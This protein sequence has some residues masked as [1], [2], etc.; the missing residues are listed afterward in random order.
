M[1]TETNQP[2]SILVF[3]LT[4]DMNPGVIV[5]YSLYEPIVVRFVYVCMKP[6]NKDD[7]LTHFRQMMMG[8]VAFSFHDMIVSAIYKNRIQADCVE[9][10]ILVVWA[11]I[12]NWRWEENGGALV[13]LCCWPHCASIDDYHENI[14]A[15]RILH[16]VYVWNVCIFRSVLQIYVHIGTYSSC[17]KIGSLYWLQRHWKSY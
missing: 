16:W 10:Q 12:K 14:Y 11:D 7:K 9:M 2:A 15:K 4:C 5:Y 13:K 8:S 3:A 6:Y 1:Q 17:L